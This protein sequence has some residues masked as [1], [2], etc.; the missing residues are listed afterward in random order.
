MFSPNGKLLASRGRSMVNI[1]DLATSS[2]LRTFYD[3]FS[4]LKFSP[5]S[6]LLSSVQE[7]LEIR[8]SDPVTDTISWSFICSLRPVHK[9]IFSRDGRILVLSGGAGEVKLLHPSTGVSLYS[10]V[11]S[12]N[13]ILMELSP[14][15]HLLALGEGDEFIK[16][17]RL[18]FN[19]LP[20][21]IDSVNISHYAIN[22]Q[23]SPCN[24]LA[25]S[26]NSKELAM[27]GVDWLRL[28]DPFDGLMSPL[29]R[30]IVGPVR[31]VEFSP[32][33][34]LLAWVE[35]FVR[36]RYVM[37]DKTRHSHT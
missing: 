15:G 24:S 20:H 21:L 4:M 2:I 10:I 5:E 12:T 29:H 9:A 25:F 26:P 6:K 18:T 14:D 22:L 28:Y 1:W 8:L 17:Y 30:G 19:S 11:C 36:L 23:A 13:F 7:K 34:K 16:I 32:D 3:P 37:A 31:S 27:G 33:G 35:D